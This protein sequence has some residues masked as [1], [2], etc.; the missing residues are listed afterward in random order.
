[1]MQ[2]IV[3]TFCK[4]PV[5]RS[6]RLI[7]ISAPFGFFV[8]NLP[9]LFPPPHAGGTKVGVIFALFVVNPW[10]LTVAA[11]AGRRAA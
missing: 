3:D 1:M 4:I 11:N 2:F 5:W 9:L 8:A 6:T 7:L 10:S